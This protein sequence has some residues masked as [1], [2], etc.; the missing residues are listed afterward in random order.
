MHAPH[1]SVLQRH[2]RARAL[3]SIYAAVQRVVETESLTALQ[4]KTMGYYYIP[5]SER[6]MPMGLAGIVIE[7]TPELLRLQQKFI[8]ALA[9]FSES[10]ATP[11]AYITAP[12]NAHV[13]K[14]LIDYVDSYVPKQSGKNHIPSG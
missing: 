9:P 3:E 11:A 8:D 1:V 6:G 12:E 4:L 10:G 2:V 13:L 5:F 14:Q 7:P